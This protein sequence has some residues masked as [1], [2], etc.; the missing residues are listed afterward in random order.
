M[1]L[2]L[3][4]GQAS[5]EI[6]RKTTSHDM[7]WDLKGRVST[8]KLG[9]EVQSKVLAVAFANDAASGS[10]APAG[11]GPALAPAGTGEEG[12]E[13]SFPSPGKRERS[14]PSGRKRRRSPS[15]SE[16]D[17]EDAKSR[18]KPKGK[19]K[20]KAKGKAKAKAQ[21]QVLGNKV[22]SFKSMSLQIGQKLPQIIKVPWCLWFSSTSSTAVSENSS[23]TKPV[24]HAPHALMNS[25]LTCTRPSAARAEGHRA[26][27]RTQRQDHAGIHHHIRRQV[28]L[29][30]V[31]SLPKQ[32]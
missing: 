26:G 2:Y 14:P 30:L 31:L 29:G 27:S 25:P 23:L 24:T 7:G 11:A 10:S 17:V 16:S 12:E 3:L 21:P 9:G 28:G 6:E 5:G 19:A 20:A 22:F 13:A 8:S 1:R 15:K 18:V 32:L 4:L